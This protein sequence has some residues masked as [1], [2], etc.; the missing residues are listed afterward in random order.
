MHLITPTDQRHALLLPR[1]AASLDSA[2]SAAAG[3]PLPFPAARQRPFCIHKATR[4]AANAMVVPVA[5]L[6]R[7][8]GTSDQQVSSMAAVEHLRPAN[9]E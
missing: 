6:R 1:R 7:P 8:Q 5:L 9:P 4:T 3:M 2:A